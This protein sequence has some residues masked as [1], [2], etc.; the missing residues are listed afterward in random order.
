[1]ITLRTH[2]LPDGAAVARAAADLLAEEV[3]AQ[4][5]LAFT[6]P[7]GR[8][9]LPFYDE[10][11]ARHAARRI[12]LTRARGFNLDELLLPVDDPRTFRVFMEQ[13][14]WVRTGLQPERCRFPDAA[15]ADPAT[16]CLHYERAI[17]DAGGIGVAVLGLGVDGHVAYIMPGDV[18]PPTHVTNLPDAIAVE[19]GIPEADRP[20]RAI[21]VGLGTLRAARRIM[22]MATGESKVE[23]VRRLVHG[24]EDPQWPCTFLRTHASIDV[25]LDRAAAARV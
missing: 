21:T 4:C 1:M 2:V 19:L 11:A 20:L 10:L 3:A 16:E 25:L 12:D 7:T 8:T 24:R 9:P 14:V 23:A 13:H 5:D 15:A 6:L 22:V 17:T 18:A